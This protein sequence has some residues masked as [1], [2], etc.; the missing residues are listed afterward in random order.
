MIATAI[1]RQY[2]AQTAR[3]KSVRTDAEENTGH[4]CYGLKDRKG[5]KKTDGISDGIYH[6]RIIG[7]DSTADR[8]RDC[9]AGKDPEA[10]R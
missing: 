2:A 4:A 10:A 5:W 8:S 6:L 7:F 1:S 3:K 9:A